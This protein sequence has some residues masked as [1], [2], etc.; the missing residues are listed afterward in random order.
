MSVILWRLVMVVTVVLRR[1]LWPWRT[2]TLRM[3][4]IANHRLIVDPLILLGHRAV[5]A[6]V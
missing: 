2:R 1:S 5:A 6:V 4:L 3:V